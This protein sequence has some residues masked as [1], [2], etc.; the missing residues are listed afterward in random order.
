MWVQATWIPVLDDTG[1]VIRIVEVGTDVTARRTGELDM[2]GR[3]RAIDRA[4]AVIEFDMHG[5]VVTANDNFLDLMGYR[6]DEVVGCHHRMF[7]P[8][9]YATSPAYRAFWTALGKGEFRADRFMR[10]GRDGREVWLQATY[11]PVLDTAGIPRRVV[12]LATDITAQ[13]RLEAEVR[14]RLEEVETFQRQ[15]QAHRAQ[16][17]GMLERLAEIVSAIGRI[18]SKTNLLALNATIEAARAGDAGR[19]FAIVASEVKKLAADTRDA[20]TRAAAMMGGPG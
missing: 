8:S 19:G 3:I 10:H 13:V 7:C 16:Q 2:A 11:N 4:Q 15:L 18:A 20:T 5:T 1:Q 17:D 12:K 14:A 6:L 9:N